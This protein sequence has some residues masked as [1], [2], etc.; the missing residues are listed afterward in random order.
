MAPPPNDDFAN[1][2]LISVPSVVTGTTIDATFTPTEPG[3][4]AYGEPSVWYKLVVPD[5]PSYL[6][7]VCEGA[8]GWPV[9]CE[10]YGPLVDGAT[11]ANADDILYAD[12]WWESE[13]D[14]T[15]KARLCA[16]APGTYW[17]YVTN[18]NFD[19]VGGN[20]TLSLSLVPYKITDLK[21]WEDRDQVQSPDDV[22]EPQWFLWEPYNQ[23]ILRAGA[24]PPNSANEVSWEL[25]KQLP[26][27]AYDNFD[28]RL[29]LEN[30]AG[31]CPTEYPAG[32]FN[33]R[34]GSPEDGEP[35][36][37]G[38]PP[39]RSVWFVWN[40]AFGP[41]YDLW[42]E[43]TDDD[44]V[45]SVYPYA[46]SLEELA[47]AIAE[48]DDSGPGNQPLLTFTKP[49]AQPVVIAVDSKGD[50]GD[51]VL[52]GKLHSTSPPANDDF[53]DREVL[54]GTAGTVSGSLVGS[55]FECGTP[56]YQQPLFPSG[57][58]PLQPIGGDVWYEF[59]PTGG[60]YTLTWTS[61][62]PVR[63]TVYT[64]STPGTPTLESLVPLSNFYVGSG[65][66]GMVE[67]DAGTV[68]FAV[69]PG[70]TYYVRVE[71][72]DDV[73]TGVDFTWATPTPE[74]GDPYEG[75]PDVPIPADGGVLSWDWDLAGAGQQTGEPLDD[76]ADTV[77]SVWRK[78]TPAHD[79]TYYLKDTSNAF[80]FMQNGVKIDFWRGTTIGQLDLVPI[81]EAGFNVRGTTYGYGVHLR[82]GEQYYIRTSNSKGAPPAAGTFQV[83]VDYEMDEYW[84]DL[85][86]WDTTT[87]P[88]TYLD[89]VLTFS[90]QAYRTVRP[91]VGDR[92][93]MTPFI[94][95]DV[96][97]E[98]DWSPTAA[99]GPVLGRQPGPTTHYPWAGNRIT[100]CRLQMDQFTSS[101]QTLDI[102]GDRDGNCWLEMWNGVSGGNSVNTRIWTDFGLPNAQTEGGEW[103][104]IDITPTGIYVQGRL[105]SA[106]ATASWV[107]TVDFGPV[108][109]P[110]R[111]GWDPG[112]DPPETFTLQF[113]NMRITDR[114]RDG[115]VVQAGKMIAE[116]E[117]RVM[118]TP[119]QSPSFGGPNPLYP[120]NPY[121]LRNGSSVNPV[122]Y[123]AVNPSANPNHQWDAVRAHDESIVWQI[124]QH[125]SAYRHLGFW[126]TFDAFPNAGQS[127]VIGTFRHWPGSFFG[128]YNDV[129]R[130]EVN[131]LGELWID[132]YR[133]FSRPGMPG[134][135]YPGDPYNA[136]NYQPVVPEPKRQKVGQ[137]ALN[138]AYW[139]EIWM[140]FTFAWDAVMRVAVNE[141]ECFPEYRAVVNQADESRVSLARYSG[142][143]SGLFSFTEFAA[144]PSDGTPHDNMSAQPWV[145]TSGNYT[146]AIDA[147]LGPWFVG[148][149]GQPV[150]P[151]PATWAG[152]P[153]G[154]FPIGAHAGAVW[155]AATRTGT[156]R[157]PDASTLAKFETTPAAMA[158]ACDGFF[159][160]QGVR[161]YKGS[162]SLDVS[163]NP[164]MSLGTTGYAPKNI[165]SEPSLPPTV[166]GD[167]SGPVG[168]FGD[169]YSG[170]SALEVAHDPS[171][172][173]N[174]DHTS[175]G[176]NWPYVYVG[177]DAPEGVREGGDP[178]DDGGNHFLVFF[179][180]RRVGGSGLFINGCYDV[181]GDLGAGPEYSLDADEAWHWLYGQSYPNYDY[182]GGYDA[183]GVW[184]FDFGSPASVVHIKQVHVFMNAHS[185]PRFKTTVDN[186]ASSNWLITPTDLV[187]PYL[188]D[189]PTDATWQS[190][191]FMDNVCPFERW[192]RTGP[193]VPGLLGAPPTGISMG[194]YRPRRF[195]EVR[196][197]VEA[198]LEDTNIRPAAIK[199]V[200]R[201]AGFGSGEFGDVSTARTSG[202][203]KVRMTHGNV[204]HVVA[205]FPMVSTDRVV[206][207]QCIPM[208]PSGFEWT[209]FSVSELTT[210]MGFHFNYHDK[211]LDDSYGYRTSQPGSAICK[212]LAYEVFAESVP[213]P[214]VCTLPTVWKSRLTRRI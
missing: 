90:E 95:F 120:K 12:G 184:R 99:D 10:L 162:K 210:R 62:D 19:G 147:Y 179:W 169:D 30:P 115:G 18:W 174:L 175:Y 87:G 107:G 155:P 188:S 93:S 97:L 133:I 190:G 119:T 79:C 177:V 68:T 38:F 64:S 124:A 166:V 4:S 136:V 198:D 200:V 144:G 163:I 114:L 176:A 65:T 63:I 43:S 205:D 82:K 74:S 132:P 128:Y 91:W 152:E 61:V 151:M 158:A 7:I 104:H 196:P 20:F 41:D 22:D 14:G 86:G 212:A 149:G 206:Q 139:I 164:D 44:Y 160:Y 182:T 51:F 34:N 49:D 71:Q 168:P 173:G 122:T 191:I 16:V 89:G 80:G 21:N 154:K 102:V 27:P 180:A 113:R 112:D 37:A 59:T 6:R 25:R 211:G 125:D 33:N 130:L 165:G 140:D 66:P 100:I 195:V 213:G 201:G 3:G 5:T 178:N 202:T 183:Y 78:F 197:P 46:T 60:D 13:A 75:A 69:T 209:A 156:H 170:E 29:T 98:S 9:Y 187:H 42:V 117:T 145:K 88:S 50:G 76:P 77:R 192:D 129:C 148:R 208:T 193:N 157:I 108:I 146:G 96:R 57:T 15:P 45:L 83:L 110:T 52:R 159:E 72:A 194:D 135:G 105:A 26:A 67:D 116:F 121:L 181:R 53:A 28:S 118:H 143:L 161:L 58:Q 171:G 39:K 199:V 32:T 207:S 186:G 214:P 84:G 70:Q 85:V 81:Q 17:L 36:H 24:Y 40:P 31:I 185:Y 47:A 2:E 54:P 167:G 73:Q 131:E 204:R 55:S 150:V 103:I 106:Y 101:Y 23:V 127:A 1:A 92:S 134:Y 35:N 189:D 141:V 109:F 56:I 11:P 126:I 48:D 94:S 142:V 172:P 8:G 153:V 111:E 123:E 137:M 138:Q 203:L